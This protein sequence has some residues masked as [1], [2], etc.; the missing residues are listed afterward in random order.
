M[1]TN[2]ITNKYHAKN[3]MNPNPKQ[4]LQR[5]YA[6]FKDMNDSIN[7]RRN[8]VNNLYVNKENSKPSSKFDEITFSFNFI[9]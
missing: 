8:I 7:D 2:Q 6:P 3:S 9:A 5:E 1:D 4:S